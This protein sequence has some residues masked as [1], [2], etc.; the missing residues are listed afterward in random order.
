MRTFALK[1]VAW[2]TSTAAAIVALEGAQQF[3]TVLPPQVAGWLSVAATVSTA[4][5]GWRVHRIVTP[6]AKPTAADGR[7][8][9]P[10][11]GAPTPA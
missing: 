3:T 8:L 1:P 2:L 10:E 5:L 4:V 6:L 9:A 11:G 7:T